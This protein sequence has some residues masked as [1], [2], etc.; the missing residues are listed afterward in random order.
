MLRSNIADAPSIAETRLLSAGLG[1]R[2][3][4]A[5]SCY[6]ESHPLLGRRLERKKSFELYREKGLQR[7]AD[8]DSFALAFAIGTIPLETRCFARDR[9]CFWSRY[10]LRTCSRKGLFDCTW[11][12]LWRRLWRNLCSR[13]RRITSQIFNRDL[14]CLNERM[15]SI[16]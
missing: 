7:V 15:R 14:P 13:L 3:F 9:S 6:T 10:L 1:F 8:L 2:S 5:I 16:P 4:L 11:T 12:G